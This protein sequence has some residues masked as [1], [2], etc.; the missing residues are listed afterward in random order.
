M[1][2]FLRQMAEDRQ[3]NYKIQTEIK[4]EKEKKKKQFHQLNYHSMHKTW[5]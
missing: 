3:N 1:N 4:K 2:T 5:I